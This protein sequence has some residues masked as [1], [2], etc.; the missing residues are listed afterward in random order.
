MTTTKPVEAWAQAAPVIRGAPP[1]FD[2]GSSCALRAQRG[3][4]NFSISGRVLRSRSGLKCLRLGAGLQRRH[5]GDCEDS[6]ALGPADVLRHGKGA[7]RELGI[8][9]CIAM[10]TSGSAP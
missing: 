9:L 1:C 4:R 7:V 3:S 5:G 10:S 8:M 6:K 2:G